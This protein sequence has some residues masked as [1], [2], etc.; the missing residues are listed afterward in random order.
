MSVHFEDS[1]VEKFS[2]DCS[3]TYSSFIYCM[4]LNR[5]SRG[6]SALELSFLLGQDDDFIDNIERFKTIRFSIELYG[7]LCKV[8]RHASF[9]QHQHQGEPELRHEMYTWKV[10]GTLFYRMECVKSEYESIVLFQLSEEDPAVSKYRYT[11]SVKQYQQKAQ[12]GIT[13]MLVEGYFERPAEPHDIYRQLESLAKNYIDPIH[14]KTELEKLVGRK[15][16]APLKRTNRRSYGYRYVLHP[17]ANLDEA[18][19]F[20]TK[21]FDTL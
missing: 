8:F 12:D 4:M 21:K 13:E 9:I 18:L 1:K 3:L 16:N 17:G 19:D 5:I 14:V 20:A 10:G 11:N 7:Q 15:G 6:Y 2:A